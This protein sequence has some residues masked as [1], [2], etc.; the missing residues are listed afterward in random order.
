MVWPPHVNKNALRRQT[1]ATQARARTKLTDETNIESSQRQALL[2]GKL[3]YV[4]QL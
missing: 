4:L 3:N 1:L 2:F